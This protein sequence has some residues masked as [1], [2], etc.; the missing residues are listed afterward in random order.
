MFDALPAIIDPLRLADEGARL[1]GELTLKGMP[2]LA[3]LCADVRGTASI[4]WQFERSAQG[5][6]QMHGP[7]RATVR[8]IC[9][10]CL[11]PFTLALSADIRLVLLNPG[12]TGAHDEADVLEAKPWPLSELVENE[13]LLAMPMIPMHAP[14][15]CQTRAPGASSETGRSDRRHPFAALGKLKQHAHQD[16]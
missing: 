4:D 9:Q 14:G 10:R 2:R 6:R 16:K 12:V 11:Q 13:L 1:C 15:E 5:L 7:V 3:G 8:V